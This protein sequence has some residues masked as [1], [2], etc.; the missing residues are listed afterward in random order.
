MDVT[1][2]VY[3]LLGDSSL[4][5][6]VYLTELDFFLSG[7]ESGGDNGLRS[8]FG[9]LSLLHAYLYCF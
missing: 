8:L 3:N 6:L 5:R 9:S 1:R 4:L 7:N 2:Y